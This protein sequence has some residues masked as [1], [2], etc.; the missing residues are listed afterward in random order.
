MHDCCFIKDKDC[1]IVLLQ[2]TLR[3]E[4]YQLQ[5]PSD[6]PL[7]CYSTRKFFSYYLMNKT[8]KNVEANGCKSNSLIMNKINIYV[9]HKRLSHLCKKKP[10]NKFLILYIYMLIFKISIIVKIV[11]LVNIIKGISP[12]LI[13]ELPSH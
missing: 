6:N 3:N 11:I 2:G 13:L 7:V 5:L 1:K 12:S 9:W 4:L 10:W 8:T